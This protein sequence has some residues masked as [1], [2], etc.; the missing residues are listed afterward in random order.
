MDGSR[1]GAQSS[2]KVEP[3][4]D[5]DTAGYAGSPDIL[6]QF[7]RGFTMRTRSLM[8]PIITPP[9]PHA[10]D[11][12]RCTSPNVMLELGDALRARGAER[13]RLVFNEH[14]GPLSERPFGLRG[15]RVTAYRSAPENSDRV[16]ATAA[17][18][19]I[20]CEAPSDGRSNCGSR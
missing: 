3:V 17:T 8:C 10:S 14:H 9:T 5:R 20:C 2:V 4:V 1:S 12:K 6:R 11:H 16:T 18:R 13:V 15:R 19:P 7:F